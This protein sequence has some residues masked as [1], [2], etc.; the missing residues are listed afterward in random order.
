MQV[1]VLNAKELK[2]AAPVFG[3]V[4]F[5]EHEQIVFCNDKDTGLKAIIGIHNTVLGPALGGTRMW[6][7][8]SEWEAVN[9]VLRLSRGMSFKSAIT[10]LNLGG[11]KAVI[12]G[13]AKKDKTP[14]LMRR[15]GEFVHSLGGKYIT[16]E[17]VGMETSDMDIVREVTPYVTGI[18][19]SKGGAGNP[20]PITAYGV[21]MGMKA[22]AK[23]KYGSDDLEGK[24]VLVQGIGHVGEALVEYLTGDGAEVFIADINEERLQQVKKQYGAHI[25]TERDIYS[26]AVDIY[27]PCALG[28]TI[29]DDTIDR[30][31]VDI[32]AGAANNQLADEV[33]HG[34][35]LQKRGI[36]YAP[37][38][39]I[40]A[41]GI[42]NVYAELENYDRQ[43]TM[44]KTENIY[45]TT[46]RI[47][48]KAEKEDITTHFAALKIAK[49][50]I[51]D[52]KK[53]HLN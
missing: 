26:A 25:Y 42:I 13:D 27:A 34:E 31:K 36:V 23:Y 14:Q 32:I 7:Y 24:K 10:G 11:G 5:D 30:L 16:A 28:A 38:F 41:G 45:N 12:M 2:K 50:R 40:N 49:Q 8:T 19:E 15:F 53:Q 20:S 46:L 4:S 33:A 9:D 47:L 17:D 39:L 52:R 22:A 43:E 48:E 35:I 44:R 18:S 51:E 3:Q 21:F 37:D 6:N 29:N 1:D